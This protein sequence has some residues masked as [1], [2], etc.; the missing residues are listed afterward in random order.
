MCPC[1][2]AAGVPRQLPPIP[3]DLT[4]LVETLRIWHRQLTAEVPV[5]IFSG[6]NPNTS[7]FTGVPGNLLVNIGSASTSSRIWVREGSTAS[8]GTNGWR[9]VRIA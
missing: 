1:I 3:S 6:A 5:S 7:G 4:A 8:A 2:S 9:I